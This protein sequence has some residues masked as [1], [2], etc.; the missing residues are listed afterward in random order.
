M[1]GV[2][3]ESLQVVPQNSVALLIAGADA[4]FHDWRSAQHQTTKAFHGGNPTPPWGTQNRVRV[5]IAAQEPAEHRLVAVTLHGEIVNTAAAVP[6]RGKAE[7]QWPGGI[8]FSFRSCRPMRAVQRAQKRDRGWIQR[9]YQM[10]QDDATCNLECDKAHHHALR[11]IQV[12][13]RPVV[14]NHNAKIYVAGH[15][16]SQGHR[17]QT[18]ERASY[19][20][21]ENSLDDCHYLH[22][23]PRVS[24]RESAL[25]DPHESKNE[26]DNGHEPRRSHKNLAPEPDMGTERSISVKIPVVG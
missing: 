24:A 3:K 19:D 16:T 4:G 10:I 2:R 13:A 26:N 11:T 22:E 9:S 12:S 8:V 23:C 20:N 6:Q 15:L 17:Q 18:H 7:E 21:Y 25:P 5:N 14:T 1:A